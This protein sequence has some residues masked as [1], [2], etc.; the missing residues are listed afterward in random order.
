MT[1]H[2]DRVRAVLLVAEIE[3]DRRRDWGEAPLTVAD[4]TAR[5]SRL[6]AC[7]ARPPAA[8]LRR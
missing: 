4:R 6:Q 2:H 5:L 1:A 7:F 8:G 3:S